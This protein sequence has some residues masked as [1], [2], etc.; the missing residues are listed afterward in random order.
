MLLRALGV[1]HVRACCPSD[2]HLPSNSHGHIVR[3]K[4]EATNFTA[5][6]SCC[7]ETSTK[8]SH[9]STPSGSPEPQVHRGFCPVLHTKVSDCAIVGHR[10]QA[11]LS[12][13]LGPSPLS[14]HWKAR[15]A[16]APLQLPHRGDKKKKH[17]GQKQKWIARCTA[18]NQC[19]EILLSWHLD[20]AT[21]TTTTRGEQPS[22]FGAVRHARDVVGV[23]HGS[24]KEA[25]LELAKCQE[26]SEAPPRSTK[27]ALTLDRESC[28]AWP[29]CNFTLTGNKSEQRSHASL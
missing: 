3:K 7:G 18:D 15:C 6:A 27:G 11:A 28:P 29:V 19:P 23:V 4:P 2:L 20:R 8:I 16:L 10:L 22:N 24:A 21:Y 14:R 26:T 25:Q 17:S 12:D 1:V 5:P 13:L 9:R